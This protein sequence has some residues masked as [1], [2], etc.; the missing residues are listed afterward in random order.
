MDGIPLSLL[1]RNSCQEE[2]KTFSF[3]EEEWKRRRAIF[4]FSFLFSEGKRE[5]MLCRCW[6]RRK[7]GKR[8]RGRASSLVQAFDTLSAAACDEE[9]VL[10]VCTIVDIVSE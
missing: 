8:K 3:A 10:L 6:K 7:N 5:G 4:L 9:E 1:W 2:M